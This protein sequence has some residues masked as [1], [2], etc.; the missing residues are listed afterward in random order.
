MA[1]AARV[2]GVEHGREISNRTL[3]AFGGNGPLHATRVA[4]KTGID[5]IIIPCDPG[6]G[7]AVG[8]LNAPISYEIIRSL[9]MLLSRFDGAGVERLFAEMEVE[10]RAVVRADATDDTLV[11]SRF[12]FM[13]YEGQGHE[14]QIPLPSGPLPKDLA[15]QLNARFEQTYAETFGRTVPN[16]EIEVMNWGVVAATPVTLLKSI[17]APRRIRKPTPKGFRKIYWGQSRRRLEVPF[18]ERGNLS[19]GDHIDGPALI[20]ETQTT[21]LVGPSFDATIDAIGNIVMRRKK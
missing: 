5:H 19:R 8:F 15:Q 16:V 21:T 13:R 18:F 7:S 20:V 9:Y 3:I 1:N 17:P 11:E 2:H 4:E 10:A 6:V 12:A 14:I